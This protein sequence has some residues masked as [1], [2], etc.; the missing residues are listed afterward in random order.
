M[1]FCIDIINTE[2][3]KPHLLILDNTLEKNRVNNLWESIFSTNIFRRGNKSCPGVNVMATLIQESAIDKTKH[4][5]N[6]LGLFFG[7]KNTIK[8]NIY[9]FEHMYLAWC[10]L[11]TFEVAK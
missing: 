1:L 11:N 9:V 8:L 3:V 4:S 6:W 7:E 2:K 5:D 10:Q